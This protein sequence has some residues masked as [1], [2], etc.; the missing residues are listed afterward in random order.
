[1]SINSIK[2]KIT[3]N[4]KFKNDFRTQKNKMKKQFINKKSNIVYEYPI[5][6][7][8]EPTQYEKYKERLLLSAKPIKEKILIN[9][10]YHHIKFKSHSKSLLL[11]KNTMFDNIQ[12]KNIIEIYQN[13]IKSMEPL[14]EDNNTKLKQILERNNSTPF[15]KGVNRNK[16]TMP[17]LNLNLNMNN[18]YKKVYLNQ[19]ERRGFNYKKIKIS[20][21]QR[22]ALNNFSKLDENFLP[23]DKTNSSGFVLESNKRRVLPLMKTFYANKIN[24][25]KLKNEYLKQ[26]KFK[27]DFDSKPLIN[28][29]NDPNFKFHI[30]HDKKGKVRDLGKTNEKGLKMTGSKMRDL[31][32]LNKI[33]QIRDPDII[34][35]YRN[36]IIEK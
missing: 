6:L 9:P 34:E 22:I 8:K 13:I 5:S 15:F 23:T 29:K 21:L 2:Q 32:L 14:N 1:M 26:K 28:I 33:R 27:F 11:N 24:L 16:T 31:I 12:N 25:M 10:N 7:L 3:S 18:F 30:F 17:N 36:A 20:S 35:K 4:F 19:I